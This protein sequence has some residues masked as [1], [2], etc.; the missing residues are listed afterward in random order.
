ML[1]QLQPD[2]T[3]HALQSLTDIDLH[4]CAAGLQ[5]TTAL[6]VRFGL[7][8]PAQPR[9]REAAEVV[10]TRIL[11]SLFNRLVEQVVGLVVPAGE[12]G[13]YSLTIDFL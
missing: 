10:T 1:L 12:I 13:V 6:E 8:G 11:A 3:L 9:V 5:L 7:V 2:G 4:R